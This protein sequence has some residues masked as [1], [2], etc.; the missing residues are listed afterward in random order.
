MLTRNPDDRITFDNLM[1]HIWIAQHEKPIDEVIEPTSIKTAIRR[2]SIKRG[3]SKWENKSQIKVLE[4]KESL[5]LKK[6]ETIRHLQE[7]YINESE[8][9][10][11]NENTVTTQEVMIKV[12]QDDERDHRKQA[13]SAC[14]VIS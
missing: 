8:I 11:D 9:T 5:K 13:H 12:S 3:L 14:C 2:A 7:E 1:K 6:E 10:T 4:R